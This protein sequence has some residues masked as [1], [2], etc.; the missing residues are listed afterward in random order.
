MTLAPAQVVDVRKGSDS[1]RYVVYRC[2]EFGIGG[3]QVLALDDGDLG[4]GT[5]LLE[6]PVLEDLV[7]PGGRA[8]GVVVAL[9]DRL[10]ADGRADD[11]R[12]DDEGEPAKDRQFAMARAPVS[13]AGR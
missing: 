13:H 3:R 6:P 7:R 4:E 10:R 11:D 12:D 2:L 9:V 1:P 8:D 5:R